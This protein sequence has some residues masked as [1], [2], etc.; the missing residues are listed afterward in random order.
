MAIMKV[1]KSDFLEET[2]SLRRLHTSAYLTLFLGAVSSFGVLY[3]C[4]EGFVMASYSFVYASINGH[5]T[6]LYSSFDATLK[7]QA[8]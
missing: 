6:P 4:L 5:L 3:G 2:V 7:G 1:K 8:C